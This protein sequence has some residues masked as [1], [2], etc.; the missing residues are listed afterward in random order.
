MHRPDRLGQSGAGFL[1]P[2]G[3]HRCDALN[4]DKHAEHEEVQRREEPRFAPSYGEPCH[5]CDSEGCNEGAVAHGSCSA[6]KL[7]ADATSLRD[8]LDSEHAIAAARRVVWM[9]RMAS[10]ARALR[11]RVDAEF[12]AAQYEATVIARA[13]SIIGRAALLLVA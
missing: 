1:P 8:R 10:T 2:L 12:Y 5:L 6:R 13:D 11:D 7:N 9:R 4:R 3:S